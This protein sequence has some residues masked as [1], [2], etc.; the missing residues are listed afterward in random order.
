MTWFDWISVGYSSSSLRGSFWDIYLLSPEL[1]LCPPLW[2]EDLK[3]RARFGLRNEIWQAYQ[4]CKPPSWY[5]VI[6]DLTKLNQ[7]WTRTKSAGS[8]IDSDYLFETTAD[9]LSILIDRRCCYKGNSETV[10][11][12]HTHIETMNMNEYEGELTWNPTMT[13]RALLSHVPLK[14]TQG[15]SYSQQSLCSSVSSTMHRNVFAV[16]I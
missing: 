8:R 9:H 7:R 12:F 16:K 14:G 3:Y 13:A 10:P 5:G 4:H 6:T 2:V 1:L 15:C 11:L